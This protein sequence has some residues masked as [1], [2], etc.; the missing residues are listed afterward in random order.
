VFKDWDDIADGTVFLQD[1][2]PWMAC[3]E[4]HAVCLSK[5]GLVDDFFQG[6]Y[7]VVD[8]KVVIYLNA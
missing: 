5:P 1:G 3:G 6:E 7:E 4:D 8:A 2:V